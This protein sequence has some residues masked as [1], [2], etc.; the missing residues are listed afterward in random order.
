MRTFPTVSKRR[1]KAAIK[2][3]VEVHPIINMDWG[4]SWR[5]RRCRTLEPGSRPSHVDELI[6]PK[7][8]PAQL[9]RAN[10][11]GFQVLYLADRQDTALQEAR[12]TDDLVVVAEFV[13]QQN[14]S[15]RVAPIGELSQVQRTGRGFLAGDTSA[16]LSN[17]LNA[18]NPD[19][20]RSL[21]ITD[22]FL[23]ECLIGHD[24]YE[25]SSTVALCIFDKNPLVTTIAFPSRRQQGALNFAV[26]VESFWDDWALVAA[27]HGRARHLAI[28]Y[29][30][31]EGTSAV[32]AV[33]VGGRLHWRP[34]KDQTAVLMRPPYH[35]AR[36]QP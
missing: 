11:A 31:L 8:V 20:A 6:W 28:G 15:V 26:R 33:T 24:D 4:G 29:F 23:L 19:E 16:T 36:G 1:K 25:I 14:H 32:D 5:Y 2:R 27:R 34:G 3:L 21:L 17:M 35:P 30:T 18:C 7:G 22:A 12:V 9:G 10:P 13:I